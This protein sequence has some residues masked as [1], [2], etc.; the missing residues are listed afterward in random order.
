M[1]ES[2]STRL[3]PSVG[4]TV[5]RV[6]ASDDVPQTAEWRPIERM[7]HQESLPATGSLLGL[8]LRRNKASRLFS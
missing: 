3:L 5:D 4:T 6:G 7:A 1:V 8:I 2:P